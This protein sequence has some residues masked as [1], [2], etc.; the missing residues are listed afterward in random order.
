MLPMSTTESTAPLTSRRSLLLAAGVGVVAAAAGAGVAFWRREPQAQGDASALWGLT[1]DTPAGQPLTMAAL[2]G[3]PLLVNF[4]A[5]WCPPCVE[6]LPML[7]R[8]ARE[9]AANGW[10]VVGLAID[11]PSAVRKFL[12]ATP[13]SFPIGLAGLEGTDLGK[14]L[15]NSAGGLPFTVVLKPDGKV[16]E[17]RMGKVAP[18]DLSRWAAAA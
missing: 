17:R 13:V 5:T 9:H 1:F 12:A 10:Q 7:D 14:S 6:E 18:G 3:K 2:R 15:G 16:R 11:Q 8:F 4:W